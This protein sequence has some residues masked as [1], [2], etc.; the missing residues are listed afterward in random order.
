MQ[1]RVF[2]RKE[3]ERDLYHLYWRLFLLPWELHTLLNHPQLPITSPVLTLHLQEVGLILR[4][5]SLGEALHHLWPRCHCQTLPILSSSFGF[6]THCCPS[7]YL[8]SSSPFHMQLTVEELHQQTVSS[9]L[10]L[11]VCKY[12]HRVW[13][14]SLLSI[15]FS[16]FLSFHT[17]SWF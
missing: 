1:A 3:D 9:K 2:L 16:T 5:F 13:T 10:V 15:P 12:L 4:H 11:H 7:F 8:K 6:R 14:I 17:F